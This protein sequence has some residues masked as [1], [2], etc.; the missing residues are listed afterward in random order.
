MDRNILLLIVVTLVFIIGYK[1]YNRNKLPEKYG[2]VIKNL[3]LKK[4]WNKWD[5]LGNCPKL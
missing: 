4:L 1:L 3:F 5:N 2:E